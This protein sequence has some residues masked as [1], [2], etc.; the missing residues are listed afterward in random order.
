M[1]C[2]SSLLPI[3]AQTSTLIFW[4]PIRPTSVTGSWM[5]LGG[6]SAFRVF[7]NC[8]FKKSR[9]TG[10]YNLFKKMRPMQP[11]NGTC[12]AYFWLL[13]FRFSDFD[14]TLDVSLRKK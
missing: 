11:L 12:D 5:D 14:P 2:I 13:K 8:E 6:P 3:V 7:K 9:I 4:V 1:Q 10:F